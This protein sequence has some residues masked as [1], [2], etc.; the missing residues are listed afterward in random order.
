MNTSQS[1][2]NK[3]GEKSSER[4]WWL[5]FCLVSMPIL[6]ILM[7][8]LC[9]INF[10]KIPTI[11]S[12][13][14]LT[15]LPTAPY[16]PY[17]VTIGYGILIG[18]AAYIVGGFGGF[19]FGLPRYLSNPDS[20]SKDYSRNDNLIQISDWLTKIIVGLGLTNLYKI[21]SLIDQMGQNLKAVFGNGEN[22]AVIGEVIV[23]YFFVSGFLMGY[24]WTNIQY[25]AILTEMDKV[26]KDLTAEKQAKET[27]ANT[28]IDTL[29]KTI[30]SN[31]P[32]D[33]TAYNKVEERQKAIPNRS[34]ILSFDEFSKLI[35][36]AQQKMKIGLNSQ[37]ALPDNLKDPNKN[38]WGGKP[39][40]ND[41]K[42]DASIISSGDDLFKVTLT[43]TSTNINNPMNNGDVVLFSLHN[44]FQKPYKIVTVID[45]VATLEFI[46]Y[47]AFTVGALC[48]DGITE[49][50]YDLTNIPNAPEKFIKN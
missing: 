35:D 23:I 13:T 28:A 27:V 40:N 21:P 43:V 18:G 32:N 7:I 3:T 24:L 49:L 36:K 19:L 17:W 10:I 34:R 46:S 48:D 16:V 50:E 44:T 14:H 2:T 5:F 25:I 6:G 37:Q 11:D 4:Q 41:R 30:S 26:V 29:E 9:A 33:S 8:A 47:G 39:I 1:I 20:P 45:N 31:D 22:G 15:I 42:L 38:Q 12:I